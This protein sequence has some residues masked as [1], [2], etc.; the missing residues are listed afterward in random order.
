MESAIASLQAAGGES[1]RR[2]ENL[3]AQMQAPEDVAP[4]ITALCTDA[5][6]RVNGQIFLVEK[7]RIGLFQPMTVTQTVERADDWTPRQRA[8]AL[9]ALDLHGLEDAYS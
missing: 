7:N 3:L 4:A 8:E 2:A 9:A 6:G 1:T 5:A